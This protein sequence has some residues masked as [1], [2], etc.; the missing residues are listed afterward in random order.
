MNVHLPLSNVPTNSDIDMG[1]KWERRNLKKIPKWH[2]TS[3]LLRWNHCCHP[4][5]CLWQTF[6]HFLHFV[7]IST[8]KKPRKSHNF[9]QLSFYSVPSLLCAFCGYNPDLFIMK[10]SSEMCPC[11]LCNFWF[12]DGRKSRTLFS[13]L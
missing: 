11:L 6:S 10:V 5:L 9:M 12:S 8:N 3:I 4:L 13:R 2:K 7:F 1:S